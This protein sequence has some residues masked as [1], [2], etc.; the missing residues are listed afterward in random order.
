MKPCCLKVDES[1]TKIQANSERQIIG[2]TI[3][4]T[5]GEC[6]KSAEVAAT[7]IHGGRFM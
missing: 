2:G 5:D 3:G 1:C 4:M 7:L 6:P